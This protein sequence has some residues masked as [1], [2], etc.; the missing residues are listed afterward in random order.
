MKKNSVLILF[1]LL[2]FS[3]AAFAA[4][5]LAVTGNATVGNNLTVTG[6]AVTGSATVNGDATVTGTLNVPTGNAI[7]STATVTTATINNATIS[8]AT[9]NTA[10]MNTATVT[11]NA[12]VNGNLGVGRSTPSQKLDVNGNIKGTGLCIGTDCKTSW[13]ISGQFYGL[14]QTGGIGCSKLV[15]PATCTMTIDGPVCGCATGYTVVSLGQ[16]VYM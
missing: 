1:I 9:M 16:G 5:D 7:V 15:A 12:T 14:C 3:A 10:T 13:N 4:G 11:G 8:T 2:S 6:S